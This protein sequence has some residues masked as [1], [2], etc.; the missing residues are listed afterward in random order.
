MT[1]G[2]FGGETMQRLSDLDPTLMDAEQRRLFDVIAG[3][4]AGGL[5]GPLSVLIRTP[6]I[7]GSA[8]SLHNAFRLEGKLD[9]AAFEMLVLQVASRHEAGYAWKVHEALARKAGLPPDIIQSIER[10][11]APDQFQTPVQQQVYNVGAELLASRG[12]ADATYEAA[13]KTL[14]TNLLIEVVAAVGFYSMVCLVLNA[15]R[16]P[17]AKAAVLQK[18][19]AD[20]SRASLPEQQ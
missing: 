13:Q 4:R 8:D 1:S 20:A 9:R 15:F 16:V 12:L 3:T 19:Q 11:T 5:G 7:A 14:G 17:E 2:R 18:A 6:H 10:G